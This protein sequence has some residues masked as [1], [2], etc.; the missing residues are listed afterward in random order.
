M[1]RLLLFLVCL[2][3]AGHPAGTRFQAGNRCECGGRFAAHGQSQTSGQFG[4]HV[5]SQGL[6]LGMGAIRYHSPAQRDRSQPMRGERR[7]VRRRELAVQRLWT[8]HDLRDRWSCARSAVPCCVALNFF[9]DPMFL[10]GKN[11]P[12]TLYTWSWSGIGMEYSWGVG[13]DLPKRFEFR[14]TGHP[15]MQRFGARDQPLGPAWLGPNGPW[16]RYNAF[17]VRKYFGTR[18]EGTY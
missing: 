14:V 11:I 3:V 6:V 4:P 10:F 2:T 18:R 15:Q 8:L 5:F 17:G 12:Q 13:I 9:Y 16:G 1:K 7:P